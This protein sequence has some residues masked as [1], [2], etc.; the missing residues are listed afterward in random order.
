M[1]SLLLLL[2][3]PPSSFSCYHNKIE[4]S[5]LFLPICKDEHLML[6]LHHLLWPIMKMITPHEQTTT[7]PTMQMNTVFIARK[8]V[9]WYYTA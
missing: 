9:R 7:I 4:F 2:F 8:Q 5:N 6:L 1:I 3:A